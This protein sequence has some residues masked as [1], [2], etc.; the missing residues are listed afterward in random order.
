MSVRVYMLVDVSEG[1]SLQVAKMLHGQRGVVIIDVVEGPPDVILMI[2]ASN[3]QK[4]A[5]RT[6]ETMASVEC[7][8]ENVKLLPVI[9]NSRRRQHEQSCRSYGPEF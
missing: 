1:K 4:L 9:A 7:W 6:I 2:E 8:T 5:E 3:R